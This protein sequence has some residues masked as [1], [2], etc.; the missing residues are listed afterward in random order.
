LVLKLEQNGDFKE[1]YN[2]DADRV[3]ESLSHR[4]ATRAGEKSISLNQLRALQ[5]EVQDQEKVA[6]EDMRP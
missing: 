3:W 6:R 1:I 5:K 4:R 2:G